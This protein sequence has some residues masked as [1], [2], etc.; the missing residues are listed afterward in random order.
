MKILLNIS[1]LIFINLFSSNVSIAS[2]GIEYPLP[3][4]TNYPPSINGGA[5]ANWGITQGKDGKLYFAN[6]YGLLIYDGKKWE[7][8]LLD[9]KYSARSIDVD[10]E[11]N[12]LVGSLGG[13]GYISNDGKGNPKYISLNKYLDEDPKNKH[14][15]YETFALDNNEVFFRSLH[16]LFFY[17]NEKITLIDKINKKKFGVSRYLNN[18]LYVAIT[19][20][21]I[22]IIENKQ[23]ILIPNSEIF[24][25][26]TITGFHLSENNNLVIFTRKSGV[27]KEINNEFIKIKNNLID[28]I[29][30][31]YRTYNLT[32]NRIGLATYEGFYIFNKHL[33]PAL[34]LD[35]NSGLRV[36]N[37]R[38]VFEDDI[39]NTWL[40]LDDGIAK[41]NNNSI[42]KYLPLKG[43]NLKNKVYSLEFFNNHLYVGTSIDIKK[44]VID[45]ERI[46]KNKF[47]KVANKDINTQVWRLYNS[48]KNL[49]VASNNGLGQIDI[50]DNYK[51]LI[52]VKITGRVY[53]FIESKIFNDYVYVRARKGI[54][55]VNKEDP[56]L[57]KVVFNGRAYFSVIEFD[58]KNELW[59]FVA[60]KGIHR[61]N[62]Q[63]SD[64][65]QLNNLEIKVYHDIY[66]L[67]SNV[68]LFKI[69]DRLFYQ[70]KKEYNIYKFD[71]N[72][73]TFSISD[74]FDSVPNI[75][76]KD[77]LT[78]KK[79]NNDTYW[80][81]FIERTDGKR[82]QEFYEFNKSFD[83]R[84]LA[85]HSLANH[86]YIRFYFFPNLTLMMSNEGIVVIESPSSKS[87]PNEREALI[88]S[89]KNN[90]IYIH[91]F[92]PVKDLLGNDFNIKKLFNYDQNKISFSVALTDFQNEGK[93]KFSYKLD[94]FDKKFSP[95]T[96]NE[97]ITYT[98][99]DPGE[100]NFN[101]QGINSEGRTSKPGSYSFSI[102]KP[103]WQSNTFYVS[104]FVFFL[105]LL[106]VTLLLRNTGKAAFIA[107]AI[108]FMMILLFFEYIS[109]I[110]DPWILRFSGGIP[111][112]TIF[113]KVL[114]GL[115]L[116]PLA[117]FTEKLLNYLE[118]K[119][120]I[121][122]AKAVKK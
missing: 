97:I 83:F 50:N 114:L 23:P 3:D 118:D 2:E 78:I 70:E 88:S 71:E 8:V 107:T 43:T 81:N 64:I 90:D 111:V 11:G 65:E 113:S 44:L 37:V 47:I 87:K 38:S 52:D 122:S 54:Y 28:N 121:I 20:L 19:G 31:I 18:K 60:K 6:T 33:E 109:L 39:G 86:Q 34:H 112:F 72:N 75:E 95:Y 102:Q 30:V 94:N 106:L 25:G 100:Y 66:G 32:D 14:I 46:L 48:N 26:K 15:I 40:G 10:H 58:K 21:G 45:K 62:F 108:N 98:N 61:I 67:K 16:K 77:I 73:Q 92:G 51:Q 99:L 27:Y 56:S 41:I 29:D 24:K 68:K 105:T 7:S 13:F 120:S 82:V 57:Y 96:K 79:N 110:I 49:L 76:N 1:F 103:W 91:N 36:D 115:L 69:Y 9:N 4:I 117:K 104:E 80:T 35:S 74:L 101:V 116:M 63:S 85:F 42:F 17:K 5:T 119:I 59:F 22:A 93:N 89:I 55:L 12:I 53:Q 84:K